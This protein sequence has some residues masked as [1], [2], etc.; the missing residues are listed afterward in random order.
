MTI[1]EI[2]T[3]FHGNILDNGTLEIKPMINPRYA[4]LVLKDEDGNE[5]YVTVDMDCIAMI[6]KALQDQLKQM[7]LE[8]GGDE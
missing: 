5:A 6:I 4:H 3:R 7:V 8:I 1:I 2:A